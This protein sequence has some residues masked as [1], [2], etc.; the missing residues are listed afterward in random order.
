M[1]GCV[2]E[3]QERQATGTCVI[4]ILMLL[5]EGRARKGVLRSTA[6]DRTE[7]YVP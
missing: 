7:R 4:V 1:S 2:T 6:Y 5:R 3:G